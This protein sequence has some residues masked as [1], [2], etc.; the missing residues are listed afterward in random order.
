[1]IVNDSA[2]KGNKPPKFIVGEKNTNLN[3]REE[4]VPLREVQIE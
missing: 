3:L 4:K 2:C 1:M